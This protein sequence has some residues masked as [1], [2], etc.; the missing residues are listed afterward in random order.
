MDDER[1]EHELS[2]SEEQTSDE[3]HLSD[4]IGG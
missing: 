4:E 3:A 1:I 2:L